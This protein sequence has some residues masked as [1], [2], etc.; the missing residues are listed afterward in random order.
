MFFDRTHN[1]SSLKYEYQFLET[2]PYSSALCIQQNYFY[3]CLQQCVSSFQLCP[4]LRKDS[5]TL[6]DS[7]EQLW[8]DNEGRRPW[9]NHKTP[10]WQSSHPAQTSWAWIAAYLKREKSPALAPRKY[11]FSLRRRRLNFHGR[12]LVGAEARRRTRSVL[13]A[14]FQ[15]LNEAQ[16][17]PLDGGQTEYIENARLLLQ[18]HQHHQLDQENAFVCDI[19]MTNTYV[20]LICCELTVGKQLRQILAS[21]RCSQSALFQTNLVL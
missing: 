14:V 7:V 16:L 5:L 21:P 19:Q 8:L 6:C 10:P 2:G 9:N 17:W 1:I 15:G 12:D 18:H 20:F 11:S 13:S 3:C 4:N